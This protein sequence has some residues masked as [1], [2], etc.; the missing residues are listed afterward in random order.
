M[1]GSA[2]KKM[3]DFIVST[4]HT[5]VFYESPHRIQKTFQDLLTHHTV[6]SSSDSNLSGLSSEQSKSS[7]RLNFGNSKEQMKQRNVVCCREITK[8][9]EQFSR[10]TLEEVAQNLG[11]DDVSIENADNNS[12]RIKGEFTVILGPTSNGEISTSRM[13]NSESTNMVEKENANSNNIIENPTSVVMSTE[14]FVF[15]TLIKLKQDG[16]RRSEAVKLCTEMT[17]ISKSTV[18]AIALNIADW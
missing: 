12:I 6:T 10:G 7:Y 5:I 14:E 9:H 1:K 11:K 4:S 17:Q 8:L 16:L 15:N 2:R 13:V 3:L 18:Y